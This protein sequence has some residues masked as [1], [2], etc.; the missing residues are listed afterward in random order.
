[1]EQTGTPAAGPGAP[2]PEPQ[3]QCRV[4]GSPGSDPA[5]PGARPTPSLSV[6]LPILA[7]GAHRGGGHLASLQPRRHLGFQ[8][9]GPRARLAGLRHRHRRRPSRRPPLRRQRARSSASSQSG[10]V[11]VL[12]LIGPSLGWVRRRRTQDRDLQHAG[13]RGHAGAGGDRAL[14]V[15]RPRST[16]CPSA[17]GSDRPSALGLRHPPGND[18]IQPPKGPPRRRSL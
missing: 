9:G 4:R 2:G 11:I 5:Q 8:P 14:R 3:P 18:R 15:M 16:P 17:T 1:M 6:S 7:A 13:G 10:I 12:M